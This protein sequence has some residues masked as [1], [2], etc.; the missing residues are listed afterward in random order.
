ISSALII[1]TD[2]ISHIGGENKVMEY[3]K[4]LHKKLKQLRIVF[5]NK[6]Q[7]DLEIVLVSDHGN[8]YQV[9]VNIDY[10]DPLSKR[11]FQQTSVLKTKK[12]FAFV[13]PEI[14][15]FGAFYCLSESRIELA[16]A[17]ADVKGVHVSMV[18]LGEN[19]I[20]VYSDDGEALITYNPKTELVRYKILK[21]K[22]P[23]NHIHYFKKGSLKAKDYFYKTLDTEYP[24]ALVRAWEGFYKN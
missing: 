19:K 21:G 15:S 5:K 23:F 20:G 12:D 16:K 9:P 22:D 6:H 8:N 2:I 4:E 7:K 13:A 10:K 17:F 3:L 18:D 24:N 11:G 14:I 1:N